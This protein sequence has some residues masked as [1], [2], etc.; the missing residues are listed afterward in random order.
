MIREVE[1]TIYRKEVR[2]VWVDGGMSKVVLRGGDGGS[3]SAV[4]TPTPP[5]QPSH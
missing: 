4:T 5:S 1:G 2:Q 3:V